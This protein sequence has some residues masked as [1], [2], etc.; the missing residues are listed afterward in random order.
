MN[1]HLMGVPETAKYLG[2]KVRFI[3]RVVYERRITYTKVGK[4]V[5]FDKRVLD[6]YLEQG[7]V[8]ATN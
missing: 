4:Y 5:K 6:N 8:E 7:T 3:R 1:P 2:V